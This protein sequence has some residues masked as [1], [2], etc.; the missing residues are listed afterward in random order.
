MS[1]RNYHKHDPAP[2]PSRIGAQP[3][4]ITFL[5]TKTSG[6]EKPGKQ[7]SDRV[8]CLDKLVLAQ[9]GGGAPLKLLTEPSC[10]TRLPSRF[11]SGG[12]HPGLT[13]HLS[14]N[15]NIIMATL[16]IKVKNGPV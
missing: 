13:Q 5:T 11:G 4:Y 15:Y 2:L 7:R 10:Q 9:G 16:T 3:C 8:P 1:R 6:Q 14:G 12:G